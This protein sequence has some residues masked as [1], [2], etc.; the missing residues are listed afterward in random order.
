MVSNDNFFD[1]CLFRITISKKKIDNFSTKFYDFFWWKN[2]K[3]TT[4][5]KKIRKT[6]FDEWGNQKIKIEKKIQKFY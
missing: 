1:F 2:R 4:K 3:T 5:S 6:Q